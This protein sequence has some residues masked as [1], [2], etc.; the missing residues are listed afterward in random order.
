MQARILEANIF[1]REDAADLL[2]QIAS[3]ADAR[4]QVQVNL[5][6]KRFQAKLT[7]SEDRKAFVYL[8]ARFV[9]SFHFLTCFFS[10]PP[11]IRDFATFADYVGPQLIKSGAVSELMKQIRA[12]QAHK[13]AVQFQ[14]VVTGAG[15]VKPR[16]QRG[17]GGT[18]PPLTKV[19]VQDMIMEIRAR[20][21]ISDEQALHIRQVI[22]EKVA[23][24]A[25][26]ATVEANREDSD[27]LD[28][29]YR[30]QVNG[31]IQA[32]YD[33]WGRWD[34]LIDIK[35]TGSGGI[36]DLMAVTVIQTHRSLASKP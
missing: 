13:A 24:P 31:E 9:R 1:T 33:E 32:T 15:P 30:G 18:R 35:Y 12:A 2:E 19:S 22:E 21:D 26:R 27:Y 8:L 28:G 23:D 36:F 25:I 5:L 14:G 20:F 17:N 11:Q 10:Y 16:S 4:V 7:H 29:P 3:G 6:R 34:E